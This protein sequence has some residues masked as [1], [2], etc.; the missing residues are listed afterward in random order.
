M[1]PRK[2]IADRFTT[3]LISLCAVIVVAPLILIVGFVTWKGLP[4]LRLSFFRTTLEGVDPSAPASQGGAAHAIVG[5]LI[6]VI[7]ATLVSVP[8]GVLTAVYLN[9]IKGKMAGV[10]RL[11]VDAMSGIPSIVAGLF[12]YSLWVVKAGQGYSGFAASLALSVLMLPTVARTTEEMLKLVPD[13]LRESSL[14]LGAPQWRTALQ[15]VV[16][17]ARVG[18]VTAV[19]LGIARVAG[20][21]APLLMTAFGADQVNSTK[22]FTEP[23]SALPLFVYQQVTNSQGTAVERAWTGAFVL[24]S[25]VLILFTL[26]RLIGRPATQR[27]R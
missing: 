8:F 2:L 22:A 21:T 10:I 3:L 19:I 15:I 11:I 18:I 23:Q 14:A 25:L 17:T 27:T 5:T 4:N 13:G 26:A 1:N 20:E 16:P 12:V 6:Q 7:L 24:I 9:E